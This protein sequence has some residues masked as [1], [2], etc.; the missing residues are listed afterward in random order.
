MYISF[1]LFR[2]R[3]RYR[4]GYIYTWLQLFL[5]IITKFSSFYVVGEKSERKRHFFPLLVTFVLDNCRLFSLFCA[6]IYQNMSKYDSHFIDFLGT[7]RIISA[8]NS[9]FFTLA[10]FVFIISLILV[11]FFFF[12]GGVS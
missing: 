2:Y 4:F 5:F 6:T 7:L 11:L 1:F 3:F 12:P 10:K 9:I 8:L